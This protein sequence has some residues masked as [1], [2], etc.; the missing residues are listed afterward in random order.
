MALV[1]GESEGR[2]RVVGL[3]SE[4]SGSDSDSGVGGGIGGEGRGWR[5]E[6]G[7]LVGYGSMRAG[8]GDF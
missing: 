2:R 8:T 7:W 6:R 5:G 3:V 1:A 4:S